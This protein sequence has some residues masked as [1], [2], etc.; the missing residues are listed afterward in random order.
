MRECGLGKG[1]R[2]DTGVLLLIA[3]SDLGLDVAHSRP[4]LDGLE[5]D[6][7]RLVRAHRIHRELNYPLFSLIFFQEGVPIYAVEG[8]VHVRLHIL[9]VERHDP[10]Q[11]LEGEHTHRLVWL[12]GCR[13]HDLHDVVAVDLPQKVVGNKHTN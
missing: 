5:H 10:D 12:H 6:F 13:A 4:E 3:K 2:G 1:K 9:I 11:A 8:R 7:F